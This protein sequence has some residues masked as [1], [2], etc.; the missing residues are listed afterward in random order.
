MIVVDD[1]ITDKELLTK[2][3]DDSLWEANVPYSWVSKTDLFNYEQQSLWIDL[4]KEIWGQVDPDT[5]YAG[6][7]YWSNGY[8]NQNTLDWHKDKD[9]HIFNTTGEL[10]HP[11]IGS[12]WYGHTDK[13]VGGYL[14]IQR[15]GELERFEPV[16]NRLIIFDSYSLH[17]VAPILT[18]TRR[19]IASNVWINKPEDQNFI[20]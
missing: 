17:R 2:L 1:F 11:F 7:E 3:Q 6:V 10:V 14:E 4:L 15:N 9:E 19:A 16:P 20:R 18:G 5:N 13:I 12:V 8:I